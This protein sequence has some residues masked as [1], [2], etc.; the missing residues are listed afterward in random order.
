[1]RNEYDRVQKPCRGLS[2]KE[3]SKLA[4]EK[5]AT[6]KRNRTEG[7]EKRSPSGH[8]ER[9]REKR[10]DSRGRSR[11]R[12]DKERKRRSPGPSAND[13]RSPHIRWSEPG[14][15][16]KPYEI[17]TSESG[18]KYLKDNVNKASQ[19]L[20]QDNVD[21]KFPTSK[22]RWYLWYATSNVAEWCDEFMAPT[23]S[24]KQEPARAP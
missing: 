14:S 7:N 23:V 16:T 24:A 18:R 8:T 19:R 6:E 20:G 21:L 3:V 2:I 5:G 15:S 1:M 17:K 12:G 10:K 9:S 11:G 22:K 13:H 4:L